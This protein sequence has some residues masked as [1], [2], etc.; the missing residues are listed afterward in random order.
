MFTQILE[1][2]LLFFPLAMGVYLTYSI[3]K[4][5][6]LTVDGSFVL[7]A[8]VFA[9]LVTSG[10]NPIL[11]FFIAILAGAL[12]G[13]GVSLIQ[14]KGR[15]T[16]LIASILAVFILS[17][18]NLIIMERPNISLL[19]APTLLTLIPE[20]SAFIF[21]ASTTTLS[22]LG[23]FFLLQSKTGLV[24]RALGENPLLL[25]LMALHAYR[26][27]MLGL[28]LSNALASFCGAMTAQIYGYADINMGFG[29]ALIGIGTVAIGEQ[30][31]EHLL[32]SSL[33]NNNAGRLLFC[34]SAVLIYFFSLNILIQY[35]INPLHIK[36]AIGFLL[37]A[38]LGVT[39]QK[40]RSHA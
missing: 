16:P 9:K 20:G 22:A 27:K 35:G 34:F 2:S 18:L 8:G 17:S 37:I 4:T 23:L 5:T 25:R 1:Q 31:R 10:F 11:S 36:M 26:Y 3:L 40:E 39:G 6:D 7:G 19:K 32:P 28:I 15:I 29:M 21:I 14:M 33:I 30:M 12:A 38:C 13:I 24:L